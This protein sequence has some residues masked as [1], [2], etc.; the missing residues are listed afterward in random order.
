MTT[1]IKFIYLLQ[2]SLSLDGRIIRSE[3]FVLVD[4]FLECEQLFLQL[5]SKA[6]ESIP[7]VIGQLLVE[8]TLQV[9]GTKSVRQMSV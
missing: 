8:Y 9:R 7:D 3:M 5:V 2:H 6:G 4:I 1:T